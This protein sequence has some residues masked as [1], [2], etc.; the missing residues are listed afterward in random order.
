MGHYSATRVGEAGSA[1][2]GGERQRVS[3]A[4]VLLKRAPL[5]LIGEAPSAL[6]AENE[7]AVAAELTDD[8]TPRTWTAAR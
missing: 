8:P 7:A 4:R 3:I 5:L 2:S 6:D 1:L